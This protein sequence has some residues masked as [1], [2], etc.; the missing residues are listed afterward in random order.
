M[1]TTPLITRLF[2]TRPLAAGEYRRSGAVLAVGLVVVVIAGV[3][4]VRGGWLEQ[5][6]T[7]GQEMTVLQA[8]EQYLSAS[9]PSA[10]ALATETG[11]LYAYSAESYENYQTQGT[12]SVLAVDAGK[13]STHIRF[14]LSAP[15]ETLLEEDAYDGDGAGFGSATVYAESQNLT[16]SGSQWSA[17]DSTATDCTCGRVPESVGP[18]GVEV[19]LLLPTIPDSVD[20]IQLSIPGFV[21]LTAQ[22]SR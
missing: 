14:A 6:R 10:D 17:P 5:L 20:E 12:L 19:S 3:I 22:V 2:R 9:A 21:P 4:F 7:G 18:G 16:W 15:E 11:Q 8:T 13:S 1:R